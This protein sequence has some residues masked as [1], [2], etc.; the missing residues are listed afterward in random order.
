MNNVLLKM[1]SVIEEFETFGDQFAWGL[2]RAK[3]TAL[4]CT[5]S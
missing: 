2:S 1:D 3:R 5:H 4:L